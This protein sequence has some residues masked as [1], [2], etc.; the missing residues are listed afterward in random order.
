MSLL[1]LPSLDSPGTKKNEAKE[2]IARSGLD[3]LT[4]DELD[5]AA[6]KAVQVSK[7]VE[8]ARQAGMIVSFQ[9]DAPRASAEGT[10]EPLTPRFT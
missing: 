2:L 1:T 7:I 5:Q 3:I 4:A 10:N 6:R 9:D 8:L